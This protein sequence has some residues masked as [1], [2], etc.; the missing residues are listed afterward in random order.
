MKK[1]ID[2]RKQVDRKVLTFFILAFPTLL[3]ILMGLLLGSE[4][5]W[6]IQI[7]L[8]FFQFVLLKQFLDN[9]YNFL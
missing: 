1:E 4:S 5:S 8:A 9:Y 6:I 7:L 2:S 3:I